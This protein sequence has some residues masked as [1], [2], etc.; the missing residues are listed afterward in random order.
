VNWLKGRKTYITGV[1]WIAWG[2]WMFVIDGNQ[3]AGAQKVLEGVSLLTLRAGV[4]K[5]VTV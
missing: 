2:A 5:T 1:A 4:S 3:A